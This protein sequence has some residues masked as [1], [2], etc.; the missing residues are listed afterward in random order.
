MKI[1]LTLACCFAI[2]CLNAQE[3]GSEFK[4]EGIA[5][6]YHDKFEGRPTASGE[7]YYKDSLTAA[8]PTLPFNTLVEVVNLEN[9]KSVVVRVND[10]GPFTKTRIIDVSRAAAEILGFVKDGVIRVK[11]K[12]VDH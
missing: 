11:V 5:S 3:T 2:F 8:H 6:Y 7:P 1:T 4:T 9:E 10:R 12:V